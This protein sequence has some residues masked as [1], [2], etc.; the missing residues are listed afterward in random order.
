MKFILILLPMLFSNYL[1]FG[2]AEVRVK[3]SSITFRYDEEN[4]KSFV[5]EGTTTLKSNPYTKPSAFEVM[6]AT[7]L[8]F[9]TRFEFE[10]FTTKAGILPELRKVQNEVTTL[11]ALSDSG[12]GVSAELMKANQKLAGLK[13]IYSLAP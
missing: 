4:A 6:I 13:H 1:V 12:V 10:N 2:G 5:A 7:T 8:T 11:N 3:K 9:K